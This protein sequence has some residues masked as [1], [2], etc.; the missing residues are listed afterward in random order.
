MFGQK[1]F[2]ALED[3]CLSIFGVARNYAFAR[4]IMIADTVFEF[5]LVDGNPYLVNEVM[6]PD[7]ST[8]WPGKEFTPGPVQPSFEKQFLHEW[9]AEEGWNTALPVPSVPR[10]IMSKTVQ[11]Y[12]E[13]YDIMTGKVALRKKE[14]EDAGV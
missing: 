2:T 5:C 8:Y 3:I 4:G 6:T 13:L 7:S 14:E 1:L 9:L 12:R 11:R 10:E